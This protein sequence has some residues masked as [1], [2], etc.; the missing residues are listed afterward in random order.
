MP[1]IEYRK[2][3]ARMIYGATDSN[4]V[5]QLTAELR[6]NPDLEVHF[7]VSGVGFYHGLLLDRGSINYRPEDQD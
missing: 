6:K 5:T 2:P 7:A 4:F 1:W 3:E